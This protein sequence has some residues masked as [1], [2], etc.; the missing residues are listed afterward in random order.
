MQRANDQPPRGR[1][2]PQPRH[3]PTYGDAPEPGR[4]LTVAAPP[5]GLVQRD[6]AVLQGVGDDVGVAAAPAQ[7][8]REPRCVPVVE[9]AQGAE[10]PVR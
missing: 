10:V 8:G 9:L 2:R 6:E 5:A 4:D 3:Q 7:P 1:C